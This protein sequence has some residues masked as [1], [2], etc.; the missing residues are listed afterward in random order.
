[1]PGPKRL[2]I[3]Q[4]LGMMAGLARVGPRMHSPAQMLRLNRL[5][6]LLFLIAQLA[7]LIAS[8]LPLPIE[9]PGLPHW[10]KWGH[11]LAYVGLAALG[12]LV[13]RTRRGR[14]LALGWLLLLGALI[15]GLQG[16]LPWRSME[17]ADLLANAAGVALGGLLALT[18]LRDGL[19]WVE[20][21]MQRVNE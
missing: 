16:L 19:V 15:E 20:R 4:A 17:A 13:C 10:D 12:M 3:H 11:L 7:L 1:M 9:P 2:D 6:W 21:S 18:P 14:W 5:W 8:L